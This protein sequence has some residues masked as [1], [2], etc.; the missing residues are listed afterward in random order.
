MTGLTPPRLTAPVGPGPGPGE[1]AEP[2]SEVLRTCR[3]KG[4]VVREREPVRTGPL[5]VHYWSF[6]G[7]LLVLYW[8]FTGK[9]P[10]RTKGNL[11]TPEQLTF[12]DRCPTRTHP[13]TGPSGE[14]I[15]TRD[16]E[17]DPAGLLLLPGS[18]GG[19]QEEPPAADQWRG[20]R[21]LPPLGR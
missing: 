18:P 13:D 1:R 3:F 8:F 19:D 5:L 10:R 21:R 15:G 12:R 9:K 11:N 14:P 2:A 20:G 16:G 4:D 7:P 17:A 6:T